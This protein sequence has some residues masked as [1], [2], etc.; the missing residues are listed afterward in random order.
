[1][2]WASRK[3]PFRIRQEIRTPVLKMSICWWFLAGSHSQLVF[4]PPLSVSPSFYLILSLS[5][6]IPYFTF[7]LFPL[8][9]RAYIHVKNNSCLAPGCSSTLDVPRE[10]R[11]CIERGHRDTV[12][13][14]LLNPMG[15]HSLWTCYAWGLLG[16][17][18]SKKWF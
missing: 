13:K 8:N 5:L 7:L 4:I 17:S 14:D 11:T 12:S 9:K 6:T 15:T 10:Q 1:M 3:R 18:P 2:S 16:K